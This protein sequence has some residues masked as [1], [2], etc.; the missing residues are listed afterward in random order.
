MR[1]ERSTRM[2]TFACRAHS[3]R[4]VI[5]PSAAG[6]EGSVACVRT[7]RR[8]TRGP[9]DRES[10]R[11]GQTGCGARQGSAADRRSR[12][13]PSA[14]GG[15]EHS[16]PG[17]DGR[18]AVQHGKKWVPKTQCTAQQG[19]AHWRREEM[20]EHPNRYA[21]PY[22]GKRARFAGFGPHRPRNSRCRTDLKAFCSDR[23]ER[24]APTP[25]GVLQSDRTMHGAANQ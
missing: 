10:R 19:A 24:E 18:G 6:R 2:P 9:A 21:L 15:Q 5:R 7:R 22:A 14:A 17:E 20:S 25:A 3:G 16:H 1:S 12:S 11:S 4:V 23:S 8:R 13:D